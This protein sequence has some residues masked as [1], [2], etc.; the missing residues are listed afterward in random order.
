M[1]DLSTKYLGLDLKNPVLAGSC[2]LTGSVDKVKELA[3]AGAGGVVLK[4]LFEEQIE[5]ELA[6]NLGDYHTD[7]P[8]AFEYIREYTRAGSVDEYLALVA[9]AKEA[10]DIPVIASINCVSDSEWTD[11]AKRVEK[12]GADGLELNIAQLPSDPKKSGEQN[13]KLYF[14][15]LK[16]VSETV[17]IPIALKMS[18]YSAGLANLVSRLAWSTENRVAGFVL[19]NR[20]YRPDI[21]IQSLKVSKADVF[22]TPADICESLR[23]IGLLS[24]NIEKDF[25]AST[26]VH[27]AEGVIKQLL[28]GAAAVQVV[29]TLYKNGTGQIGEILAGLEQWME[30]KNFNS[31]A[32]FRGRLSY[33]KA[34]N[35]APFERV[36]F[37]KQFGGVV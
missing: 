32:E 12:A 25:A 13:E 35:P 20:Y 15:I 30:E 5:A 37:M 18:N 23:W 9:D 14:S 16:K 21:D 19:F 6:A 8:D 36:Q 29:S 17:D 11:F 10:V 24:A 3:E 22:S 7:Y 26:G 31:I 27:D 34:E 1:K 33:G 4:S 2:G 28:A